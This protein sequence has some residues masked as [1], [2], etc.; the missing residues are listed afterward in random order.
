MQGS[1]AIHHGVLWVGREEKTAYARPFDLDGRALGPGF[2]FRDPQCGRACAS[3]LALDGDH[4]LWVADGPAGKVRGFNVMGREVATL[5]PA[6]DPA[7]DVRGWIGRPVDVACDASEEESQL[8]VASIG[9]RRHALQRFT[10]EGRLIG[11]L[12]PGGDPKGRFHELRG[13]TTAGPFTWASEGGAGRIQVF[14]NDEHHYH[15]VPGPLPRGGFAPSAVAPVGDGRLVLAYGAPPGA[16][17][18]GVLLVE[19]GGRVLLVLAGP[20][21][22]EGS[23]LEPNDLALFPG[24][25]DRHTRVAVID[26]DGERVQ[27]FNLEGRCYGAFEALRG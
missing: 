10:P 15:L 3:G 9:H 21:R 25:D 13:V 2:S 11:S 5:G 4:R 14:R 12:R 17:G 8:V 20:G 24:P 26:L 23:V 1:L 22:D 6:P 19:P 7:A 27:V 16:E 18:G